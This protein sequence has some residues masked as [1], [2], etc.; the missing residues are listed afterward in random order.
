MYVM[1][2]GSVHHVACPISHLVVCT[3][4]QSQSELSLLL[5]QPLLFCLFR[6]LAISHHLL[7]LVVVLLEYGQQKI[8][9]EEGPEEYQKAEENA[10]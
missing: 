2:G 6:V 1:M 4:Q 5:Q 9:D 8:Q 7:L 3:F 10:R